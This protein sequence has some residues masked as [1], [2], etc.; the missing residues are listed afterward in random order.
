VTNSNHRPWWL[1]GVVAGYSEVGA[2]P[3]CSTSSTDAK[4]VRDGHI[5]AFVRAPRQRYD[6]PKRGGGDYCHWEDEH[7][8]DMAGELW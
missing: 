6:E 2:Q 7:K 8:E 4:G 3:G 5:A 1:E